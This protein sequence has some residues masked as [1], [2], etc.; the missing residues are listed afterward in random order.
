ME[1]GEGSKGNHVTLVQLRAKTDGQKD[2]RRVRHQPGRD[3]TGTEPL[4]PPPTSNFFDAW[5][6]S[7]S[8]CYLGC[9]ALETLHVAVPGRDRPGPAERRVASRPEFRTTEFR[10]K[11]GSRP[12]QTMSAV[13][14]Y[15]REVSARQVNLPE[16]STVVGC[17]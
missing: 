14:G 8:P 16:R 10:M 17:Y 9:V 15:T 1:D 7:L 5:S 2:G 4:S 12:T 13:G 11:R 3:V 6:L